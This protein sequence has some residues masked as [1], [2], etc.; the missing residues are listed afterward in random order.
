MS[1]YVSLSLGIRNARSLWSTEAIDLWCLEN[2]CLY[3]FRIKI[4]DTD[5]V[6][7][8]MATRM[9]MMFIKQSLVRLRFLLALCLTVFPIP[10]RLRPCPPNLAI[11]FCIVAV[12][13]LKLD[14][15]IATIGLCLSIYHLPYAT[16]LLLG[17]WHRYK[18]RSDNAPNSTQKLP[19]P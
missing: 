15:G 4:S 13:F 14:F 11:R 16:F 7:A 10:L 17:L 3:G 1:M 2:G 12:T 5:T 6:F 8:D 9:R 19:N 18:V